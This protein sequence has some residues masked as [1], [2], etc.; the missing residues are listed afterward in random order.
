MPTSENL[1]IQILK[2]FLILKLIIEITLTI[3]YGIFHDSVAST[4]LISQLTPAAN[5]E[6]SNYLLIKKQKYYIKY[7]TIPSKFLKF[8]WSCLECIS[9]H[10]VQSIYRE[11]RGFSNCY[12]TF[13]NVLKV[14]TDNIYFVQQYYF[15]LNV[16]LCDY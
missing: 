2:V 7:Y 9:T 11:L 3:I 4:Y 8:A 6:V 14:I 15:P 5:Q 10:W 1:S 16:L 12:K 13:L